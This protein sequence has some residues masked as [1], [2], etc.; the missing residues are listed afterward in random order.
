MIIIF[1]GCSSIVHE[2]NVDR[3]FVG[4]YE[5]NSLSSGFNIGHFKYIPEKGINQNEFLLKGIFSNTSRAINT[6]ISVI[7]KNEVKKFTQQYMLNLDNTQCIL[8]GE[9]YELSWN[10][11]NGETQSTINY[12]LTYEDKVIDKIE[13]THIWTQGLFTIRT[14]PQKLSFSIHGN[15]DRLTKNSNFVDTVNKYCK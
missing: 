9:I 14:I 2:Y 11:I 13:I 8:N 7:V 4:P 15:I 1:S 3:V 10:S 12:I 6:N 5:Q